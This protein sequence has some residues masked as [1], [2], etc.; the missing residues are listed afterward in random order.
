M[1]NVDMTW[2]RLL[3]SAQTMTPVAPTWER[4][5]FDQ[6]GAMQAAQKYLANQQAM[7][8][9]KEQAPVSLALQKARLAQEEN[10]VGR[11]GVSNRMDDLRLSAAE[12]GEATAAEI[13]RSIQQVAQSCNPDAYIKHLFMTYGQTACGVRGKRADAL[14][15]VDC[16][17]CLVRMYQT[18]IANPFVSGGAQ[19]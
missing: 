8:I 5:R 3:P 4:P 19:P 9:A 2:S 10:D 12:R 14:S 1:S 18:A 11:M 17:T 7:G 15:D 16:P 13:G 6:A